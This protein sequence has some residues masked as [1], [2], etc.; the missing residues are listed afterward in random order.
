MDAVVVGGGIAG[1]SAAASLLQ[2]GWNVTVLERASRFAE[3]GAGLALTANGLSALDAIGA[4]AAARDAGHRLH[5]GGTMDHRG[6]WLMRIPRKAGDG[7]TQVYG[8]HRQ[9]LHALLVDAAAGSRL[10]TGARV[11]QVDA[12]DA[13]DRSAAVSCVTDDGVREYRADLV[14]GADGI[15]SA[16]RSELEPGIGT[17]Y[18]GKSSWRGIVDDRNLVSDTFVVRWGQGAE[19]GA[20]RVSA[21]QVYWYGYVSSPEGHVWPDEKAAALRRFGDWSEV[22]RSLIQLTAPDRLLRH[23]VFTLAPPVANY[24]HGRTVLVGDAAHAMLPTMGQGANSSLEDGVCVGLQIAREVNTGVPLGVALHRFDSARRPRTQ[25]IARRSAVTARLG[26]DLDGRIA[27]AVRAA[28]MKA[29]PASRVAT[30]GSSMLTW[31]A[32]RQ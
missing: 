29:L 7:A 20:V 16:V 17:K 22:V 23:D 14:I 12:G 18:S 2:Q 15:R 13:D 8:I 32:P 4:G 19:F 1:L 24:V 10:V 26:A 25:R 6:N 9:R 30:A 27:I 5:I 11:T 31:T 21:D 28:V 3:V